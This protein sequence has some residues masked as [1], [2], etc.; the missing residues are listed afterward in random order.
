[1]DTILKVSHLCKQYSGFA[2]T[3]VS[4]ELPKG[5]IMGLIG[6]N[7]AG[8]TTTIKAI[9][10]AVRRDSGE[11]SLL[12]GDNTGGSALKQDLGVVL[13]DSFF[14]F[15]LNPIEIG[16]ILRA[17]Y[18]NWDDALYRSYLG[19]FHLPEKK[20]V[21]EFSSGMRMK[22]AIAAALAHHP[23]LLLLDEPTSGL[24]PVVRGEIL[25]VFL[26]FIQDEEHG[27]LL[28][29][30]ITGDLEKI[31]DYI[32]F[33]HE[34]R[35][36]LSEQKDALL[37]RYGVARCAEGEWAQIDARY[38]SGMRQNRFGCE[39]LVNDRRA[40]ERQCPGLVI[41]PAS[42]DDIMTDT[43]GGDRR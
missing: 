37:E 19:R 27:I 8:K 13:D 12:G 17:A 24:D 11:I 20:K 22:L 5:S 10:G 18:R 28:S 21:K 6:E 42:L 29:S 41:D 14:Y 15:M 31:A 3:D 32:T 4:F 1:M 2:L 40:V 33:L 25:D 36:V 38:R 34:G 7:G 30:H 9:I 35:V 26:D 43:V 39:V 16:R 23:R